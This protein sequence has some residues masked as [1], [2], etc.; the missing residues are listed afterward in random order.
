MYFSPVRLHICQCL[1]RPA[2][3]SQILDIIPGRALYAGQRIPF[4]KNT[5]V[6]P[7][8]NGMSHNILLLRRKMTEIQFKGPAVQILELP[9]VILRHVVV[10]LFNVIEIIAIDKVVQNDAELP[11]LTFS[12]DIA[13]SEFHQIRL[14]QRQ[15]LHGDK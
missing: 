5:S 7:V 9:I 11:V 8:Y 3:L 1:F 6:L 12:H 15:H 4:I 13:V 10:F 2:G 14:Q